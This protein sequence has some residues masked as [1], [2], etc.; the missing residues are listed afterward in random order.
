[1]G[2]HHQDI[3]FDKVILKWKSKDI[4]KQVVLNGFLLPVLHE[5][6]TVE[7]KHMRFLTASAGQLRTD[8]TQFI[9]DTA[10]E[11][12]KDEL[13][14]GLSWDSINQHGGINCSKLQAYMALFSSATDQWDLSIQRCLVL[15]DFEADVTGVMQYIKPDYSSQFGRYTV[16]I[17]HVDGCGIMLPSL[18]NRNVMVRG[19]WL[20][21]LLTPFDF[22]AFCKAHHIPPKVKDFW[23]QEHDLVEENIQVLFTVSQLKLAK[24]YDSWEDYKQCFERCGCSLA[25]TN[26]EEDYIPDCE[27]NYQMLGTLRDF[28]DEE[29]AAFTQKT[30][31]RMANLATNKQAMLRTL[32]ADKNSRNPYARALALYPPLLRDGYSKESI[33]GIKKRM[34]NDAR[35]GRI[36]CQNKRI[37]VIPDWYAACQY[38]FLHQENPEGL[39][40]DGE[41]ASRLHRKFEE[42]DCLRSPSLY[43]EH[44]VRKVVKDPEVY[45]WLIS[46]G[47]YTSCHDL[48]SRILQF[49][50]DGDA[51]N[52]V[53]E[54]IIVNI[55]KRNIQE[56]NIV[57]L[58]YD[59]QK[60][61]SAPISMNEMYHSILRAHDYSGIGQVSN[62]LCKLWNQEEPDQLAA[63]WL[64][65]YNNLVID[66]AKT[67]KINGYENYPEVEKRILKATGG[68]KGKMPHF[69]QYSR[70]GRKL[71][72]NGK[73]GKKKTYAPINGSTMNRICQSFA[74]PPR[75]NMNYA[76]VEPFV[77]QMFLPADDLPYDSNVVRTFCE[78]AEANQANLI[79]AQTISDVCERHRTY[80]IEVVARNIAQK[81][82]EKYG[83]L[84]NTYSSIY[85]H[86]FVGDMAAKPTYKQLFW[87]IFGEIAVGIL[88]ENLHTAVRCKSCNVLQPAWHAPAH[89]A[90]CGA[91]G[92]M[93][94]MYKCIECGTMCIRTNH[95]QIR[96]KDCQD[97]YN[98]ENTY[99]LHR[100]YYRAKAKASQE[101][102]AV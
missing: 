51:L 55:A 76:D 71:E 96:C 19:P 95:K 34:L 32:K 37:F 78:L 20:K 46:N 89:E 85:K 64:T 26:H 66:A 60:A 83:T 42:I 35:S 72:P 91:G 75:L 79:Q 45:R 21:G 13:L 30:H 82:T 4:L 41:V 74:K 99:R 63:A 86:L 92:I 53:S 69:F 14:C 27:I 98:R 28:T 44:A 7:Q 47:I 2:L 43:M 39:L 94:E 12:I 80:N 40:K 8:K 9:S 33:K 16:K 52:C 81:L 3:T 102:A 68:R 6:G 58:F 87:R 56:Y 31:L 88:Q 18:M 54:P 62:N 101:N 1:M 67:G 70:N 100:K 90:Q 84:E 25:L 48:I 73:R 61:P 17:N 65:Y 23:G 11:C 5:D 93:K 24:Y 57:P 38:Y 36:K 29:I 97:R 50:C 49:D 15:P 10:W 77:W 59:A 22:L